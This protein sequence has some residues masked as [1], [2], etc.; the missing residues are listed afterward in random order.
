MVPVCGQRVE[1]ARKIGHTVKHEVGQT[2]KNSRAACAEDKNGAKFND[3][4][5]RPIKDHAP[6]IRPWSKGHLAIV[7]SVATRIF[8]PLY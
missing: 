7:R 2:R 6:T 5:H 1:S 3:F 4:F 8:S